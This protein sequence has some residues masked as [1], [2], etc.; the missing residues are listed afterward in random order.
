MK[1]SCLTVKIEVR[2]SSVS[3]DNLVYIYYLHKKQIKKR[4]LNG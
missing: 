4:D 2:K 1:K 3:I